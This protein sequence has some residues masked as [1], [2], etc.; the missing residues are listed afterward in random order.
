MAFGA[1]IQVTQD[2][3]FA[4]QPTQF[5][6]IT[7]TGFPIDD[8]NLDIEGNVS[9]N[10]IT[11]SDFN[12]THISKV[13][14]EFS[15]G[16]FYNSEKVIHKFLKSETHV[17]TLKVWSEVF[18]EN[19]VDFQFVYSTNEIIEVQ[20][21]FSKFIIDRLPLWEFIRSSEMEDLV[22][23]AGKYFDRL[24]SDTADLYNLIDIHKMDPQFFEYMSQT[25]GHDAHYASKV[26]YE[27]SEN[28]IGNYDIFDRI[29][30]NQ[31]TDVELENFRKFLLLSAEF[32]RNKG[33]VNSIPDLLKFMGINSRVK[34]LWTKNWGVVTKGEKEE[35]YISLNNNFSN[36]TLG[37]KWENI[38]AVSI[39]NDEGHFKL[40]NNSI[41]LDSFHEV[42]KLE[43]DADVVS[44]SND[45]KVEFELDYAPTKIL[46][47]LHHNG[48]EIIDLS[49]NSNI[50]P[51]DPVRYNPGKSHILQIDPSILN[52][53]DFISIKYDLPKDNERDCFVATDENKIKDF[54]LNIKFKI[55]TENTVKDYIRNPS[56]EFFVVFR[57]IPNKESDAYAHFQDFYRF[58]I[59]TEKSTFS[60]SKMVYN[61]E[62]DDYLTQNISLDFEK[63]NVFEALITYPEDH[64]KKGEIFEFD[65]ESVY[66]LVLMVNGSL[67]TA[68]IRKNDYETIL[69]E[70]VSSNT[71]IPDKIDNDSL[72]P[73]LMG[74]NFDLPSKNIRSTDSLGNEIYSEGYTV[75]NE[76]G[77]WGFGVRDGLFE[78]LYT[79][80]N[81]QDLDTTLF[82]KTEKELQIKP[83]FLDFINNKYIKF[84]SFNKKKDFTEILDLNFTGSGTYTL[85]DFQANSLD[86]LYI[87]NAD[88]P[89]NIGTRYAINFDKEWLDE[90]FVNQEEVI[91]KIIIPFGS[92]YSWV[93]PE[94]R[95]FT[96]GN[97]KDFF[98]NIDDVSGAPGLF[99]ANLSTV[100]DYYNTEPFDNFSQL[101]RSKDFSNTLHINEKLN[102]F[103]N[104]IQ[105]EFEYQGVWEEVTPFSNVFESIKS[106]LVLDDNSNFINRMF[107]PIV[108]SNNEGD[109]VI[110]VRFKNCDQVKN[111]INR[112][113]S[114]I[115]S[116]VNLWA[117]F[118][119]HLPCSS[120]KHRPNINHEFRPSSKFNG[121]YEMDI[122]MSLGILNEEILDYSLGLEFV[123]I[124]NA[125]P[126]LI[127]LNGVFCKLDKSKAKLKNNI[128]EIVRSNPNE[129]IDQGTQCRYFISAR[130]NLSSKLEKPINDKHSTIFP[131]DIKLRN[132]ISSLEG[133]DDFDSYNWWV[134][135]EVWRRREFELLEFESDKDILTGINHTPNP[136]GIGKTWFGREVAPS[137]DI[138]SLRIRLLDGKVTPNANYYAK[139]KIFIQYSGFSS[140][141]TRNLT[142]NGRQSLKVLGGNS[143][144][145]F[146][147]NPVGK[148]LEV[149]LPISWTDEKNTDE[150]SW[151]NF[152][153]GSWD[154]RNSISFSPIGLMTQLLNDNPR[155][156]ENVLNAQDELRRFVTETPTW[157]IQDYN[158]YFL[159]NIEIEY[160]AEELP[161]NIVTLYDKYVILSNENVN[162]GSYVNIE[163]DQADDD[164]DWSVIENYKYQVNDHL[165]KNFT[166]D[167]PYVFL[168][169]E[170][171]Y[172]NVKKVTMN[173]FE[174]K[175]DNYNLFGNSLNI[176]SNNIINNLENGYLVGKFIYEFYFDKEGKEKSK[177]DNFFDKREISYIPY[178]ADNREIFEIQN[179]ISNEELMF[180]VGS[181]N[182]TFEIINLNRQRGFKSLNRN[183]I[184]PFTG[185]QSGTR[186]NDR[187]INIRENEP[188]ARRIYMINEDNYIFDVQADIYFDPKLNEIKNYRGKKFEVILKAKETINPFDRKTILD[189]YYFAGVGSFDFDCALGV[190]KFD[191]NLNK[192]NS[193]FLAGFGDYDTKNIKAGIWYTIR[194]IVTNDYIRVLFNEK[195]QDERLII[196]YFINKEYQKDSNRY[197]N[198]S[199]EELSYLV[200]GLD[201]LDITYPAQVGSRTNERFVEEKLDIDLINKTR[202]NGS[203][204]GFRFYNEYTYMSNVR[205]RYN[206]EDDK[207]FGKVFDTTN[208][209]EIMIQINKKYGRG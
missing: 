167:I 129:R 140:D 128:V 157:N 7:S 132:F 95:M 18:Q 155:V 114:E 63:D 34:D 184:Y 145:E 135:K 126:S 36:N 138:R 12:V 108:V 42:Q 45:G 149:F 106:N 65:K 94:Y 134:P 79:K 75:I 11:L 109:K 120:V 185:R 44:Q 20:S 58:N 88:I 127:D 49:D 183:S 161:N 22:T 74:F 50:V 180:G 85:T 76:K 51:N 96:D 158:E 124:T 104:S 71:G 73:L 80:L 181:S 102:D 24:H 143:T 187:Q 64:P 202:P 32:F 148:C 122:M 171:W 72:T 173:N 141:Q 144:N 199:F 21:R 60:L 116:E 162:I 125:S 121:H 39:N 160:I 56:N 209:S 196:N 48:N 197:I 78:V 189:S 194:C 176:I 179:R 156:N 205:Y 170:K 117:S 17:I 53:G 182:D 208:L 35:F 13:S 191:E 118:K 41:I 37:L 8:G 57:G 168:D 61:E 147:Q 193:S 190:R 25:F 192:A 87:N 77:N 203:L 3:P 97:Y 115:D 175:S 47:I 151:G 142:E 198:G 28:D 66:E 43:Y 15:D 1:T 110:G 83:E 4:N 23:S 29:E 107:L 38:R 133:K 91:E 14:W 89:Q 67:I 27:L 19:G 59:N 153:K 159:E 113:K 55:K 82:N 84:N 188:Y 2:G 81:I 200:K 146:H 112:Y 172:N 105:N 52:Q 54:D 137:E 130:L 119:F 201:S 92:Q 163:Y 69:R 6:A 90:N 204:C 10:D 5:N 139:V 195:D 16:Y 154:S 165:T 86:S 103:K 99:S 70:R 93:L 31:A 101:V 26:G 40:N 177:Q 131:I 164:F 150:I 46:E 100:L 152:L 186:I 206:V 33:T 178:E 136:L 9:I 30:R 166:F 207:Q 123:K 174:I 98:G 68:A 169:L 111:V 62:I